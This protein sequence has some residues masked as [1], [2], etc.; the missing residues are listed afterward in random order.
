MTAYT[1]DC[2]H[3]LWLHISS[4][5]QFRRA[6]SLSVI[7][8][9][10]V[11]SRNDLPVMAKAQQKKLTPVDAL[12]KKSARRELARLAQEI[13]YHDARYHSEDDPEIADADYDALRRRNS[14][15]EVRF[16]DLIRSDSPSK[17]VGSAPS[18]K[19]GKVRHS[20]AMLSLSNAFNDEDVADFVVR[21]RRFLGLEDDEPVAM[22]AE[23]KI[24]G[25][26]IALRY[27]KGTLVQAATRGDGAV[28]EDVTANV[29]AIQAIPD[30]LK[31]REL[32]DVLEVRGEIYMSP[33]DFEDLNRRQEESSSKVFANP[34][35]AAA[36][37]LRQIDATVTAAR[38]LQFF[39][40]AWGEVSTPPKSS[41]FEMCQAFAN[42]GLPVNTDM[43]LVETVEQMLTY[44]ADIAQRR[45]KLG[46][47]IDG[48]VYKVDDIALQDRLGFVSRSPRWA[49]AHKFA[50]E[51]AVT[52]LNDIDI[53]V[54]RTGALTPVAK[55]QP[56]TV[57]GVVVSNASL[58]NADE[59]ARKDVR[60][61]DTVI[62]QRA[63]DVIPQIV[64]VILDKRPKSTKPFTFP[65]VCPACGSPRRARGR[66]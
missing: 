38:P 32:P 60:V 41:Q 22:T 13:A 7:P 42:W 12:D 27:E 31:G 8:F 3:P 54:G 40:Y 15:I 35:N 34:R 56:V 36:G 26:S 48:V 29:R 30:E 43:A 14:E 46:Y 25:L 66:S 17:R 20:V 37:S 44:Y 57:G 61:G 4:A 19:F 5:C 39:A 50:A 55:L 2:A 47:D 53:Q 23:P 65:T 18:S 9:S 1:T 63:G 10:S 33:K 49:I 52:T 62:V 64:S 11:L 21:V 51:Q 28:G 24:D 16:P 45:A 58:H 6:A 59:I